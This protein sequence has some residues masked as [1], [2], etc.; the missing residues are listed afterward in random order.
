MAILETRGLIKFYRGR[1]VVDGVNLEADLGEIVGLLGPNGA[2]K[3]TSFRMITGQVTPNAGTVLINGKDVA[4]LPMY[5]RA[6]LGLGYLPQQTSVFRKLTVEQNILAILEVLPVYRSLGRKLTRAERCKKTDEVLEQFGLSHLRKNN[7]GRLSG[8]E[9]RRL[10]IARCLVC[11]PLVILLDEPFSGIDPHTVGEIQ[12]IIRDLK[13]QGIGILITDHQ[14]QAILAVT[15]R[16]YVIHAGK[17]LTHGSPQEIVSHPMVIKEYLGSN[18]AANNA[19]VLAAGMV[20]P[21]PVPLKPALP[22]PPPAPQP[23]PSAVMPAPSSRE[24]I[25]QIVEREKIHR[26]IERLKTSDRAAAAAELLQRG[27]LAVSHLLEALERRD[28]DLRLAAFEVLKRLIGEGADFD[29]HAPEAH[30]RRQL[31]ALREHCGRKAG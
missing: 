13:R 1:K 2:G 3:T 28:V 22:A 24:A 21:A 16:I 7:A 14:V 30:R 19:A 29:P 26:L 11:D 17:V 15:D 8:G 10:E 25:H 23:E 31:A 9:T 12:Q 20:P 4:Q 18:F 6:R 27:D 5:R